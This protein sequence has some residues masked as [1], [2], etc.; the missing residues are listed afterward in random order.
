VSA[1]AQSRL[2]TAEWAG[3]GRP[4]PARAAARVIGSGAD[5]AASAPT[6]RPATVAERHGY[7]RFAQN[8][9]RQPANRQPSPP[10]PAAS[11]RPAPKPSNGHKPNEVRPIPAR[12]PSGHTNGNGHGRSI[13]LD[14]D[15]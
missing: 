10:P 13:D 6:H 7:G 9:N 4:N 1:P 5:D 2:P 14:F 11:V 3:A 8:N 12:V 15:D